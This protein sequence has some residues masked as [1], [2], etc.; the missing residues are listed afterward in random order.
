MD[1]WYPDRK[2]SSLIGRQAFTFWLFSVSDRA[3]GGENPRKFMN[4]PIKEM[5]LPLGLTRS[6]WDALMLKKEV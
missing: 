5:S 1:T 4:Q 2:L 3:I 6:T